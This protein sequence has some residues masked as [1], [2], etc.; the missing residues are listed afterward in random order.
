MA[1]DWKSVAA[2]VAPDMPAEAVDRCASALTSLD[3]LFRPLANQLPFDTEP[4]YLLL[5]GR[6][7]EGGE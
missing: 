3:A 4:A 5:V 6:G 7:Q 2:A 1:K